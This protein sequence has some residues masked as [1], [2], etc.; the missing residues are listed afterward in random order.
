M[1]NSSEYDELVD[2]DDLNVNSNSGSKS[3]TESRYGLLDDFSRSTVSSSLLP[4]SQS[5][6]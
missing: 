2:S 3:G 6:S 4:D 5:Q 1:S